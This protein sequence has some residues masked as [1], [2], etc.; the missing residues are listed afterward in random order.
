M[1]TPLQ[2]RLIELKGGLSYAAFAEK[3]GLTESG[4]RKYFPPL[5][6]EPTLSKVIA[7]ASSCG[8]SLEWLATGSTPSLEN[9]G[10]ELVASALHLQK[11]ADS[12]WCLNDE[13]REHLRRVSRAIIGGG[14]G[15]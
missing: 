12:Q 11:V 9:A 8:V 15:N 14:E 2:Q 13:T 7:I 6:S 1:I 5:S 4:V 3:C 10:P